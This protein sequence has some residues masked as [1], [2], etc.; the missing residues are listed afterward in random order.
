MYKEKS[1]YDKVYKEKTN[2]ESVVHTLN[3]SYSTL[4]CTHQITRR[5]ERKSYIILG[6]ALMDLSKAF[7]CILHDLLISKFSTYEFNSNALK[8]I[9]T[10]FKNRTQCVCINKVSSD[11]KGIISG[12]LQG[13]I[14]GPILVN[15]Y[16]NDFFFCIRTRLLTILLMI[17]QYHQLPGLLNFYWIY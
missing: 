13:S 4:I 15:A 1:I 17:I 2:D 9:Y 10:Y 16:L 12:V 7:D 8:Y 11:F 3:Q 5:M 6:D 14:D